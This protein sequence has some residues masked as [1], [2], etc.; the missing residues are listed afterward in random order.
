MPLGEIAENQWISMRWDERHP[1]NGDNIHNFVAL[2]SG[3]DVFLE[4]LDDVFRGGAG[5]EGFGDALFL[6][7][8]Q[9]FLR[10]DAADED[11]TVVH[12]F[13]TEQFDN[14]RAKC[15]MRATQY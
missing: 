4:K 12:S 15:V 13:F 2:I 8:G 7:S 1:K 11:Q 9:V 3:F 6:E 5:E 10:D 14:S